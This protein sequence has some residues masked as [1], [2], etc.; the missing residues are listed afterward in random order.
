METMV[1]VLGGSLFSDFWLGIPI[2]SKK[3]CSHSRKSTQGTFS[4]SL[5][6]Y[7]IEWHYSWCHGDSIVQFK[8]IEARKRVRN[9]NFHQDAIKW[10]IKP[11]FPQQT[12]FWTLFMEIANNSEFWG[13]FRMKSAKTCVSKIWIKFGR[14]CGSQGWAEVVENSFFC[15]E[16][17]FNFLK[18]WKSVAQSVLEIFEEVYLGGGHNVPPRPPPLVGIGLT[19]KAE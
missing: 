13:A 17:E 1:S 15:F 2:K 12:P 14:C 6:L 4:E 9:K 11:T 19:F 10:N 7:Q 18:S 8:V 16:N 5:F 3:P